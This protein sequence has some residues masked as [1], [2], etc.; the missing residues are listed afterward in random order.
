MRS[1]DWKVWSKERQ[2]EDGTPFLEKPY[3]FPSEDKCIH[4]HI[5]IILMLIIL[6]SCNQMESRKVALMNLS[7][8]QK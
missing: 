6:T 1:H 7:E 5:I 8:G 3:P 2:K 4:L